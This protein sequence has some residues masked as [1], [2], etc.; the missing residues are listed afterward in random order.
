MSSVY[1][2]IAI[3]VAKTSTHRHSKHGSVLVDG[4]R[5]VSLSS[6]SERTRINGKMMTSTHSEVGVTYRLRKQSNSTT[7]LPKVRKYCLL[8]V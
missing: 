8:R 2:N 6:N 1:Q 4:N 5:I 3:E 7:K